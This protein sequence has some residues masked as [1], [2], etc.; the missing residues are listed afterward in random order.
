MNIDIS[1][2]VEDGKQ[3][4]SSRGAFIF[5][6]QNIANLVRA[7]PEGAN[8]ELADVL[9]DRAED[10]ADVIFRHHFATAPA[11]PSTTP[12]VPETGWAGEPMQGQMIGGEPASTSLPA[13]VDTIQ[14]MNIG[15]AS[16]SP[17]PS[18]P[19]IEPAAPSPDPAS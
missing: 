15:S 5:Y 6:V 10:M 12:F 18:L 3:S 1:K 2:M 4:P 9:H 16:T 11:Q 8:A 19:V 14:P 13:P 7:M 17:D